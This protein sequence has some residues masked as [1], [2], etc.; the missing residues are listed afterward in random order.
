MKENGIVVPRRTL[1]KLTPAQVNNVTEQSK[2]DNF[3]NSIKGLL[4]DLMNLPP[5]NI[6]P[7]KN[8]D[9]ATMDPA[10]EYHEDELKYNDNVES[11]DEDP[12]DNA[13]KPI[14]EQP[15]YDRLI[16][17]EVCIPK[18][19]L[20]HRARVVGRAK[21]RNDKPIGTYNDNHY[22]NSI[23]H[24]VEF[25]DDMVKQYAANT[26]AENILNQVDSEGYMYNLLDAIIDYRTD[27]NTITKENMYVVTK[28]GRR[29]QR[30]STIGWKLL[31]LWKD[32]TKQW[33][34]L[35]IVKESNPVECAEY[36]MSR[37]LQ[38]ELAINWWVPYTLKKRDR[39]I[40]SVNTRVRKATHKYGIEIPTS[41][42][43]AYQ[44]D[45]KNGNTFW[46]D[47]INKEMY[48]VSVAFEILECNQS[49]PPD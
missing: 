10:F 9:D 32:G 2:R 40:A 19:E 47:V 11:H 39:V 3:D 45:V 30:R 8:D 24:N 36:A 31:V 25:P 21:D 20:N 29:R 16:H 22:L 35:H 5:S 46:R 6:K 41:I 13:G 12:M 28:R 44:L 15:F 37:E 33:I 4:D 27:G 48:N 17:A 43:H 42:E 34:P 23:I 14:C 49:P 38:H 26:I 7:I 18:G 1:V